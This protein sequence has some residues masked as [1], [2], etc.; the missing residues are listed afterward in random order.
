MFHANP[1]HSSVS[2]RMKRD[3]PA[4]KRLSHLYLAGSLV[5]E[6]SRPIGAGAAAFTYLHTDA[7]GSPIAKTNSSGTVIETVEY[8][9][10]GKRSNG[11]NDDR[12]GY[13][14]HVMDSA[15]GLTYMQQRYYDPV[16][17]RFI[18]VDP[19]T[20]EN[21]GDIRHFNRFAYANNNPYRFTDPDGREAAD[22][23]S[24]A[25]ARDPKA[26]TPLG[27]AAAIATAVMAAPVIA[28]V[29]VEAGT[30]ALANP[31]ATAS[32]VLEVVAGDAVGGASL[33]AGGTALAAKGLIT[34]SKYFGSKTKEEVSEAMTKKFGPAR[35]SREGAETFYNGQA[36]RSFNVHH[37][38]GHMDGKPHVDV[39]RR[40]DYE[41]RKYMLKESK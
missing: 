36:K 30:A 35:S 19:V 6:L 32:L 39:R 18:S 8:E 4:A 14:G 40:G 9:P 10:Y 26:F 21:S 29:A 16:I 15:S 28:A 33:V 3:E 22:R 2:Q 13:T 17:G 38:K 25:V 41:E 24:D 34:P 37:E 1:A 20:M 31:V 11:A 27:P 7:L 5:A 23:L 12:P